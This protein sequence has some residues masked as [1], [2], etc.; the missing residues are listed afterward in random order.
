MLVKIQ[1]VMDKLFLIK[2]SINI[3]VIDLNYL[4]KEDTWS[5]LDEN[6]LFDAE[7]IL[8]KTTRDDSGK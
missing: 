2:H 4:S 6:E 1:R 3:G 7:L 5:N 8:G